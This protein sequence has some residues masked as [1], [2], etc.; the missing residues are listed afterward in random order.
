L[1]IQ[2]PEYL[3]QDE[4]IKVDTRTGAFLSRA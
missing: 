1:M 4:T 3:K 2:V